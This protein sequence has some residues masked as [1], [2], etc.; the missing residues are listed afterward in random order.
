MVPGRAGADT[1]VVAHI[2]LSQLR[3]MD[4]ASELEAAYLAARAG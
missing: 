1:Q 2:A 4:G 3:G